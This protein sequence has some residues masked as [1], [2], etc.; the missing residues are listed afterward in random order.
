MRHRLRVTRVEAA[1]YHPILIGGQPAGSWHPQLDA[2]IRRYHPPI[3]ASVLAMPMPTA[4]GATI[5]WYSDLSDQPVP[6]TQLAAPARAQAEALLA[7]RL[8]VLRDLA[9]RLDSDPSQSNLAQALRS[10]AV[11][12]K[13]EHV[14]VIGGQPVVVMWGQGAP[15]PVAA[16][17]AAAVVVAGLPWWRRIWLRWLLLALLLLLLLGLL[18]GLRGCGLPNLPLVGLPE[19][20]ADL[21][22]LKDEEARLRDQAEALRKELR[23]RLDSCPVPEAKP[24][25]EAPPA[26]PKTEI[27]KPD[28]QTPPPKT[29]EPPKVEPKKPEPPKPETKPEP[30]KEPKPQAKAQTPIPPKQAQNCPPPRQKW[31]APEVVL[32]LD[33]SG[34]MAFAAGIPDSEIE[35]AYRRAMA[36][37][38]S[39]LMR[40]KSMVQPNGKS[41]LDI[42]RQSIL[43]TLPQLPS[44]VDVG[45]V[46]VGECKGADNYKFFA[47]NERGRLGEL[48]NG[49]K[50]REGTPLARG[51]E[52]AANMMDGNSVPGVL[53]V[54]SDGDESCGGDPCAAARAI[55]QKKPNLKIN[56][57]DVNGAGQDSSACVVGPSG[58]KVYKMRKVDEL[59]ELV[60]KSSE[61]PMGG[62][63]CKQ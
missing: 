5:E 38:R 31:E 63:G 44:D 19:A 4:D 49:L 34:S 35:D 28:L 23:Q 24:Q 60:R 17:L 3:I 26:L 11:P 36:G 40:L 22:G 6:L 13:P 55:A 43:E 29:E 45:L 12:P 54:V 53:I 50:P 51:I 7:E 61:Q 8:A 27:T 1:L 15:V 41:R 10:A 21:T 33:A 42:A 62:P 30:P 37:D 39:A 25:A 59:P 14:F 46:V 16:P 2:L 48:L 32:L 18:F 9:G 56:F 52:R 20:G 57:I 47:P 58:G